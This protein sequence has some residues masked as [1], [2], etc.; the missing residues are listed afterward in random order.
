M[1]VFGNPQRFHT[2]GAV[3]VELASVAAGEILGVVGW[4]WGRRVGH[5]GEGIQ[6][7]GWAQGIFRPASIDS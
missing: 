4:V 3:G 2:D 7:E 5:G 6:A 1:Q